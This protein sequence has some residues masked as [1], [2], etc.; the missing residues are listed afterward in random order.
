MFVIWQNKKKLPFYFSTS[1]SKK[2]FDLIHVDLWRPYL[3]PSIHGHKYAL[4]IVDDYSRYTWIFLLKQK[5][6]VVKILENFVV[7][8][9]TQ[10]ETTIKI[11]KSN[12]GTIFFMTNFFANKGIIHQVSFVNTLQQNGIVERKHGH[13]SVSYTHLTLPTKRIV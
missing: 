7:F 8:A 13:I 2:C 9:Q 4:T 12:N 6:E 10:F 3:I 11:I 1:K 5:S